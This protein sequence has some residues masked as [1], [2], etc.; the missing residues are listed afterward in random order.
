MT[1]GNMKYQ[2]VARMARH[3][4]KDWLMWTAR[5]GSNRRERKTKATMKQCLLDSGTKRDWLLVCANSGCG[6][7]EF[8]AMGIDILNQLKRGYE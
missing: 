7:I 6:M 1:N 4:H 8:H 5:D 3:G 2:D